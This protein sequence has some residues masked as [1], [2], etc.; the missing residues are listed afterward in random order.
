MRVSLR[1]RRIPV[2][3]QIDIA[4]RDGHVHRAIVGA[5]NAVRALG[6]LE[7]RIG[8]ARDRRIDGGADAAQGNE[9]ARIV[10]KW[11]P[12]ETRNIRK[13]SKMVRKN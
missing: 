9:Y 2:C 6:L 7:K 5:V 8:V 11:M 1:N 10:T 13:V 4:R 12:L 3:G